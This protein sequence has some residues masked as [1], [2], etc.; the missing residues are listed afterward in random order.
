MRVLLLHDGTPD[1]GVADALRAS[2]HRLVRC[3]EPGRPAFPCAG[4][5]GACPLD[6]TVD[7]TVVV[8][9]RPTSEIVTSAVGAVC[10]LRDAVPLVLAGNGY[11]SP[12]LC[13]C[14]AVAVSVDDVPAACERA[15]AAAER[16][17]S[18]DVTAAA[19]R[20]AAVTRRGDAVK[21]VL[22]PGATSRHTVLAHQA[23]ARLFPSARTIDVSAGVESPKGG[24][25]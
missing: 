21:V 15:V 13:R 17:A 20:P 2:G 24:P 12:F 1:T 18:H 19:G 6:G 23:A 5:E 4:L 16:R 8:H 25:R 14:D 3:S 10:S 11:S 9:D 22:A 7:V